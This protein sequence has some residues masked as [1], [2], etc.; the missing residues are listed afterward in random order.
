MT[1]PIMEA[2]KVFEVAEANLVKLERLWDE[3]RALI[4]NGVVFGED[5]KYEDRC[6]AMSALV[7]ALPKIDGWKPDISTPDLNDV[8]QSRFDAMD[9]GEPEAQI[10]VENWLAA[11]G[12]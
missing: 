5:P 6:R 7:A 11:P 4:P 1:S 8:A 9:A 12:G 3:I 2:L 10:A